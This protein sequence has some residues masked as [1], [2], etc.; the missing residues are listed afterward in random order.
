MPNIIHV[1]ATVTL[2]VA[3][4]SHLMSDFVETLDH[5]EKP[6]TNLAMCHR[7]GVRSIVNPTLSA[8]EVHI[9]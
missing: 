6:L 9:K 7:F 1:S 8:Q 2:T 3:L 4:Y 5:L